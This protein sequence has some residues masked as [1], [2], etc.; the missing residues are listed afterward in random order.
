MLE[1]KCFSPWGRDLVSCWPMPATTSFTTT[2]I[3]GWVGVVVK[4]FSK[5]LGICDRKTQKKKLKK[6]EGCIMNGKPQNVEK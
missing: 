6:S 2:S 3:G 1:L 5:V 4:D